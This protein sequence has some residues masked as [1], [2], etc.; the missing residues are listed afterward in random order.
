MT[1]GKKKDRRSFSPTRKNQDPR[2]NI[3]THEKILPPRRKKVDL[4]EKVF[5]PQEK[6]LDPLEKKFDPQDKKF[7]PR[8][9]KLT[10]E[11]TNPRKHA[12]HDTHEGRKSTRFRRIF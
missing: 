4:R 11:G 5:S 1:Y 12:T 7:G 9:K 8:G 10:Q 2:G 6:I 3:L